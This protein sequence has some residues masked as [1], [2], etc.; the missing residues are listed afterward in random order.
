VK[1]RVQFPSGPPSP[2]LKTDSINRSYNQKTVFSKGDQMTAIIS[3]SLYKE[4]KQMCK[5]KRPAVVANTKQ[6]LYNY[7][8]VHFKRKLT[9][10]E[11]AFIN[12]K[13]EKMF[14]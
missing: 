4:L 14:S 12:K 11:K 9:D 2:L 5:E 10:N 3:K 7:A 6:M 8:E 1:E 13:V